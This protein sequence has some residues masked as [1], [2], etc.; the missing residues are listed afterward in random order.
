MDVFLGMRHDRSHIQDSVVV[1][2]R[3]TRNE[4]KNIMSFRATAGREESLRGFKMKSNIS[5]KEGDVRVEKPGKAHTSSLRYNN[6]CRLSVESVVDPQFLAYLMISY[7]YLFMNWRTPIWDEVRSV[8][9]SP[10]WISPCPLLRN[11][12]NYSGTFGGV[13]S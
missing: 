2:D 9:S 12:P 5:G 10:T 13:S 1:T 6:L 4:K 11:S 7:A 8:I 3:S